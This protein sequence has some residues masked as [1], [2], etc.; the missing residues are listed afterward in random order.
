MPKLVFSNYRKR[1]HTGNVD[2]TM[3]AAMVS[4][5]LKRGLIAR[6]ENALKKNHWTNIF[7]YTKHAVPSSWQIMCS[8]LDQLY[9]FTWVDKQQNRTWMGSKA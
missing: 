8:H 3:I 6:V 4:T 2:E 5:K 1:N 9:L 7:L